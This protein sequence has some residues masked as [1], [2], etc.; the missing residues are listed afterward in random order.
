[1][2]SR[3]DPS[4]GEPVN[5]V[6]RR[7]R[8]ADWT[9]IASFAISALAL[10]TSGISTWTANRSLDLARRTDVETQRANLFIQ[11]QSHF[12]TVTERF[13]AQYL[14]PGFRPADGSGEYARLEGFW[15][16]C[17]SE[18]YA[19]H[20]LNSD[21][22]RD[23]WSSYYVPLIA[24]ALAIPSLRYVIENLAQTDRL[25]RGGWKEFLQEIAR[26]A[27]ASGQPLSARSEQHLAMAGAQAGTANAQ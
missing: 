17:F 10:L 7:A 25:S 3:R 15:L 9:A 21:S 14:E 11:F 16:L 20:R 5:G 19:T 18:W 13:P 24:D 27:R 1:M 12:Y 6:D 26:I 22:F 8:L 4:D 2:R 23:L